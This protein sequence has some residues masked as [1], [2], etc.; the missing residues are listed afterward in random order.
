MKYVNKTDTCW[1]W[2]GSKRG[3]NNYGRFWLNNKSE[4]S[5]RVSYRIW[6]GEIPDGLI[7]R[8]KCDN[9]ICVNPDHLELG[10]NAENSRDMVNRNRS[11]KGERHNLAK[12][13]E[14]SVKEIRILLGFGITHRELGR[15]YGV[16]QR[17]IYQI[18]HQLN[19]KHI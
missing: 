16:N 6:N 9:P 1:L 5:H 10:T 17:V 8:H 12:L 3:S 11:L 4:M 7:V 14:D 13:T 18:R 19:W 2:T 15:R